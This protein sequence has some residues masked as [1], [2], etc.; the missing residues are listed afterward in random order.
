MTPYKSREDDIQHCKA[1]Y[2]SHRE[3]ILRDKKL[4]YQEHR[5]EQIARSK[6]YYPPEKR[7]EY[8]RVYSSSHRIQRCINNRISYQ[9]H[10]VERLQYAKLYSLNNIEKIKAKSLA[11]YYIPLSDKC[12][13]CNTTEQLERHHYD[14]SRPL[15]VITICRICHR[16]LRQNNEVETS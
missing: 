14:Y 5:Q 4:Y 7:R 11:R 15:E 13:I 3:A 16:R 1:Y 8:N 9:R 12:S 10:R 2:D 6:R